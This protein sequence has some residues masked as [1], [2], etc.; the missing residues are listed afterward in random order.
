MYHRPT[1]GFLDFFLR[2]IAVAHLDIIG[3][4]IG[5]EDDIL[6]HD[7]DF[8]KQVIIVHF[9]NLHAS[10]T[11]TASLRFPKAEQQI[12]NGGLAGA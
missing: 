8:T 12:G 5:E 9:P 1:C 11:D 7:T 4:S 3:N 2:G 6:H 10:D